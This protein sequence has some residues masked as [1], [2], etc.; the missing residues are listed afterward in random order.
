M[1]TRVTE[2]G[3]RL[4]CKG[5]TGY[6]AGHLIARVLGGK[7]GESANNV[8]PI[9]SKVNRGELRM[10]EAGIRRWLDRGV[11]VEVRI[12]VNYG[13]SGSIPESITYTYRLL[14]Y[15]GPIYTKTFVNK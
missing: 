7:G 3:R 14:V 10:F 6:D 13:S 2:A 11:S 1:G 12:R 4:C 9:L 15:R 5:L 8:V